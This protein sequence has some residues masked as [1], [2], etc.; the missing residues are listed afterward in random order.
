MPSRR[1]WFPG[2]VLT[3]CLALPGAGRAQAGVRLSFGSDWPGT[4]A[5]WYTANPLHGMNAA[6]T[7]QTLD[8]KPP[9]GW[10]PEERVDLETA[11]R[12]YTVNNAWAAGEESWKGSVQPGKV[13]DLVVLDRDPFGGPP[14]ELR[15]RKVLF[16]IVGGRVVH[17][18]RSP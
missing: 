3:T 16:T 13:A 7:R 1:T 8:G 2:L 6:T 5:S 12:A 17:E 14:A 9:A 15:N 10:F 18:A 4:K 11:L